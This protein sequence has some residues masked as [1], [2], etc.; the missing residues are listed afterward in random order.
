MFHENS[1]RYDSWAWRHL[2]SLSSYILSAGTAR[3]RYFGVQ[4]FLLCSIMF[5]SALFHRVLVQAGSCM[6]MFCHGSQLHVSQRLCSTTGEFWLDW[7]LDLAYERFRRFARMQ[8]DS[9][10]KAMRYLVQSTAENQSNLTKLTFSILCI[11]SPKKMPHLLLIS[12]MYGLWTEGGKRK[13]KGRKK[14]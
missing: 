12:V 3:S 9:E 8:H 6:S 14:C 11:V 5:C 13:K 7:V 1:H 10:T 2:S 4:H